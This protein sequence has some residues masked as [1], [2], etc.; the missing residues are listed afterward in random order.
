MARI[1]K[2]ETY[3]ARRNEIL[4]AARRL[5][6]S[7]GYE[8][9]TIQDMLNDLGISKGAFYHYFD[10]KGAVLEALI[11]RMVS[12][13]VIPL[14]QPIVADPR[15]TATEKL[16]RYFDTGLRWKVTQ[17]PLMLAILRVWLA[18]EN[19]IVRQ[20]MFSAT[21]KQVTPLLA[22]IIRQGIQ[23]GVFTTQYPEQTCKVLIYILQ[24]LSDTIIDL[25]VVDETELD[26]SRVERT[27]TAYTNALSD[28]IERVLGA[29]SGS[30]KLIDPDALKDWFIPS[31]EAQPAPNPTAV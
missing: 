31:P 9:M 30:L 29:P 3:L 17:K 7:K 6:Y 28:A 18:D 25:L 10:S 27:V 26:P 23:E 24:G 14:V 2:E 4:A 13:E 20:K 11:E 5:V 22:E 16:E 1:T 19:A 21:V 15:L 12:E 8:Q